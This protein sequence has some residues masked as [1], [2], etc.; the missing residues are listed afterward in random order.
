[1]VKDHSIKLEGTDDFGKKDVRPIIDT[2]HDLRDKSGLDHEGLKGD[3]DLVEIGDLQMIE[4]RED[5][6]GAEI[7]VRRVADHDGLMDVN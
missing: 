4:L 1:M 6:N 3:K 7:S 5:L 2:R